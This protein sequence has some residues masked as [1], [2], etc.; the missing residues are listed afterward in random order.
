MTRL[1][2]IVN[3][4]EAL[5]VIAGVPASIAVSGGGGTDDQTAAEVP[6]TDAGGYF[7]GTDVEAALQE[8]G[9]GGGGGGATNLAWDA[10][11]STVSSDT[12]TDATLSAVDG[13]NPGLM[14]VAQKTKLDGIEALA[15]V[16]DATN[17]AAAGAVMAQ[18]TVTKLYGPI[19]Q[20]AYDALTPAADTLYVIVG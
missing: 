6:I 5:G 18:S 1:V 8:L 12:G 13:T 11:T 3:E 2:D 10:A 19:T 20:A 4:G 17:V 15:D 9:A 7:T 16:T 14:S